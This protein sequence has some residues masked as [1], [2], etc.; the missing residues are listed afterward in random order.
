MAWVSVFTADDGAPGRCGPDTRVGKMKTR[1]HAAE[2]R[3]SPRM[4]TAWRKREVKMDL[5]RALDGPRM[6]EADCALDMRRCSIMKVGLKTQKLMACAWG[7]AGLTWV[8]ASLAMSPKTARCLPLSSEG[9]SHPLRESCCA[10]PVTGSGICLPRH[11][12][13]GAWRCFCF[14]GQRRHHM[15]QGN[16]GHPEREERDGVGKIIHV[17]EEVHGVPP[18]PSARGPTA[19]FLT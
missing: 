17:G 1:D 4:V 12:P 11:V 13:P 9:T 7:A 19:P 2:W 18:A 16:I 8:A 6:E 15:P 10:L 14:R 5:T 3:A